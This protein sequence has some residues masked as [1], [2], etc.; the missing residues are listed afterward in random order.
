MIAG[1]ARPDAGRVALGDEVWF[2]SSRGIDVPPNERR[3][4]FVFQSLALF[5]HMTAAR[6][7]LYGMD[8]ALSPAER[9]VDGSAL[10]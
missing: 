1:L 7:V 3:V 10:I 5:P 9:D 2:D 4:A 8:R 6:N